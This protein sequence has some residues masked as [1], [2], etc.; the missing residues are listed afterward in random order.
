MGRG[1]RSATSPHDR[2]C[3]HSQRILATM[4]V[5][6]GPHIGGPALEFIEI[7]NS[8][9]RSIQRLGPPIEDPNP[10]LM[11]SMSYMGVGNL[12]GGARVA[13][14]WRKPLPHSFSNFRTKL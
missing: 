7:S 12:G 10:P 9:S 2:C 4:E 3:M 6:S 5:G 14:R 13:D 11:F 1:C 8:R